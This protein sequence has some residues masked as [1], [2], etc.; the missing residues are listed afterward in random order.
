[1]RELIEA[2]NQFP[3]WFTKTYKNVRYIQTINFDHVI[4]DPF[5]FSFNFDELKMRVKL[6]FDR[7]EDIYRHEGNRRI[8]DTYLILSDKIYNQFFIEVQK[9]FQ[10]RIKG[11]N[12]YG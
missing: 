10:K 11:E 7:F 8:E 5:I 2:Y 1:M 9:E 12:Y 4:A 6:D 3:E